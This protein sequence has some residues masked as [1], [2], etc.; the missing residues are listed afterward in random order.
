MD[1]TDSPGLISSAGY[2]WC[3]ERIYSTSRDPSVQ[4]P[5]KKDKKGKVCLKKNVDVENS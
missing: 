3:V 1:V 2:V 4:E 5:T